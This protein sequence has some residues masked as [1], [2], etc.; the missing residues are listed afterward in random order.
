MGAWMKIAQKRELIKEAAKHA[1]MTEPELAAWA[2]TTFKLQRP[3]AQST[4]SD[5]LNNAKVI[6]CESYGDGKQ[7]KPFSAS[8]VC[9]K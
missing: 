7:R 6:M 3:P 4:I 2:M 9:K 1:R 5:I 8:R